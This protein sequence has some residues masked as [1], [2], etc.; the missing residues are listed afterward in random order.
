MHHDPNPFDEGGGA[1]DNPFSVR[2]PTPLY[3][4]LVSFEK[5]LLSTR[6]VAAP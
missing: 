5:P 2:T 6:G 4:S 3:P 1:D